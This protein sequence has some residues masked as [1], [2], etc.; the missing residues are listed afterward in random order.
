M[1]RGGGEGD[2]LMA[3]LPAAFLQHPDHNL[4]PW[5]G[6]PPPAD[7]RR[8]LAKLHGS[9]AAGAYVQLGSGLGLLLSPLSRQ[10]PTIDGKAV[11]LLL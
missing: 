1:R 8:M 9:F 6:V 10:K 3:P 4:P 5:G 11:V 2:N 7:N